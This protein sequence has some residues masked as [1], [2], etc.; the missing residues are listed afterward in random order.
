VAIENAVNFEAA[1]TLQRRLADERDRL[2]LLLD[3]T[4]AM[5]SNLEYRAL[6]GVIATCLRR[7]VAHDYTSLGLYDAD[8]H[9]FE[10]SALEFVG[11][12]LIKEHMLVPVEGSPAG[13]AFTTGALRAPAARG[14]RQR[15][16]GPAPRRRHPVDLQ[17]AVDRARS[18]PGHAHRRS[19][20]RPAVH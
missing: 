19:A 14:A 20:R 12:G 17:R 6:F 16:H 4:N 8:R 7:V 5:V 3:V 11:K 10:M 1:Q 18:T 9:A 13:R 2:R 15:D